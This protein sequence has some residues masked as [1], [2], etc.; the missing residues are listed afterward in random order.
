MPT[1]LPK[2]NITSSAS[3]LSSVSRFS[4]LIPAACLVICE[5]SFEKLP[6]TKTI[7][8]VLSPGIRN[9]S[10]DFLSAFTSDDVVKS[11]F[12]IGA[13]LVYFQSS[14]F[15]VGKSS[16]SNFL[17]A[18]LRSWWNGDFDS[19]FILSSTLLNALINLFFDRELSIFP[20]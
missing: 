20:F 4:I 2:Y 7:R 5:S 6:F 19:P 17:M 15:T 16:S 11:C 18:S 13:I 14:F 1:N 8:L 12:S 3:F 9:C 10:I